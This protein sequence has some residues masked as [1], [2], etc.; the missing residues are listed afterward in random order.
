MRVQECYCRRNRYKQERHVVD[1]Q[2][3]HRTAL[4]GVHAVRVFGFASVAV[5]LCVGV[6]SCA[7]SASDVVGV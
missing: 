5:V 2:T 6:V 4:V 1:K 3:R 7:A